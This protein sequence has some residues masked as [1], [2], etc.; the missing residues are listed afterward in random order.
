MIF[1]RLF[2]FLLRSPF[3]CCSAFLCS[4]VCLS[5][6]PSA[7]VFSL[8]FAFP[9]SVSSSGCGYVCD[10]FPPSALVF[11]Y[12]RSLC[13]CSPDPLLPFGS[14]PCSFRSSFSLFAVVSLSFCFACV[15]SSFFSVVARLGFRLV[16][17]SLASPDPHSWLLLA[18]AM[19][20]FSR[21]LG[22]FP[23]HW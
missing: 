2:P 12:I 3:A 21:H 18:R 7:G 5:S 16:L 15:L 22:Y 10:S 14:F 11:L 1:P 23:L 9:C 13:F 19:G 4:S 6:A 8:L 17:L 20:S